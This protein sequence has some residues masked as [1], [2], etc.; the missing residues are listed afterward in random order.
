[1]SRALIAIPP[2]LLD[3]ELALT[4]LTSAGQERSLAII[5]RLNQNRPPER[6]FIAVPFK[7]NVGAVEDRNAS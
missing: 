6:R 4:T 3:P 5:E 1:M 7:A 2:E